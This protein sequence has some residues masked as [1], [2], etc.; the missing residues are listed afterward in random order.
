MEPLNEFF[1]ITNIE[2]LRSDDVITAL[3]TTKNNIGMV[4]VDEAH[5]CKNSSSTQGNNLLKL[6]NYKHKLGLTGT[7]IMNKPLDAYTILK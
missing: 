3:K 2:T 7:L 5:K 1:L 4:V 6:K